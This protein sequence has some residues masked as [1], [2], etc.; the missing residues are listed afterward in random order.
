MNTKVCGITQLKQLQQL[1]GLD[2]DF[3]GLIFYKDSPRYVGDKIAKE[4]LKNSDFDLKKVGVFV[5]AG[6]DEI[7]QVVE[8]YGLDVV[9]LHGDESP[10]LCEEL[11]EDVEVIKAFKVK[12]SKVSIDEMV[13]DYDEVCDYYLFDTASS[14]VEGGSGKQFDWKLLSKSKIEKPFFLSGGIGV[15]DVAKVKAFKHPD[16]YAVDINSK[17]EKEPGVKDMALVLQ[18][19]QGLK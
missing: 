12:D 13:A 1:D 11:S 3:A 16:Y 4:D 2:I 19:R 9:Q 7:M 10:D 18:F 17:V 5:N 6:Y 15:D 14:D 8:D